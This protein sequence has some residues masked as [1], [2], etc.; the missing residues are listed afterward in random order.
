MQIFKTWLETDEQNPQNP[1]K[2]GWKSFQIGQQREFGFQREGPWVRKPDPWVPEDERPDNWNEQKLNV[3]HVTTNLLGIKQTFG[4]KS[5]KQLGGQTYG[6]GGG[7]KNEASDKI[8][9]TYNYDKANSIYQAMQY[10]CSIV[11]NEVSASSILNLIMDNLGVYEDFDDIPQLKVVLA[12]WVPRRYLQDAY[13]DQL[14]AQL[15]AR[16]VTPEQKYDFYIAVED[17]IGTI[18]DNGDDSYYPP[19]RVGF[20]SS[21][22][23]MVNIKHNQIA[24]IQLAVRKDA[25]GEHVAQEEEIRFS[26]DDLRVVRYLQP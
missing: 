5:R 11:N 12:N 13:A 7:W 21:F 26:P 14:D 8:S 17:A 2:P 10:M 4:L 9:T 16:I 22:E 23:N 6:L 1:Q 18:D 25:Q 3:Y 15:D 20:T 19:N 24:I